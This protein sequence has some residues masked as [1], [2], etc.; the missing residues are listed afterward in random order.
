M[1][2]AIRHA[3]SRVSNLAAE[4]VRHTIEAAEKYSQFC[5]FERGQ[6]L[7]VSGD[8]EGLM[9]VRCVHCDLSSLRPCGPS[10]G[11]TSTLVTF[12]IARNA[13]P[14]FRPWSPFLTIPTLSRC[15]AIILGFAQQLRQL[16]DIRRDPPRL[17][18]REQQLGSPPLDEDG[19]VLLD[20]GSLLATQQALRAI[21]IFAVGRS[22]HHSVSRVLEIG[23][24]VL[25]DRRHESLLIERNLAAGCVLPDSNSVCDQRHRLVVPRQTRAAGSGGA[26]ADELVLAR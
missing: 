10:I 5:P 26:L 11:A 15:A 2:T 3:S 6:S 19:G 14:V 8:C 22:D 23:P 9:L 7:R 20:R 16:G 17:V 12:G 25:G 4:R 21:A 18:F 24:V 1:F 13:A